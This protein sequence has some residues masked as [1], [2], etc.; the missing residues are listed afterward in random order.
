MEEALKCCK[1]LRLKMDSGMARRRDEAG[2]G[3][4][5]RSDMI[6]AVLPFENYYRLATL[7]YLPR[8]RTE[9]KLRSR[10]G[11]GAC[12]CDKLNFRRICLSSCRHSRRAYKRTGGSRES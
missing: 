11:T 3:R 10:R 6:A 1:A 9:K 2:S 12:F 8:Q 4:Q 5:R 7:S